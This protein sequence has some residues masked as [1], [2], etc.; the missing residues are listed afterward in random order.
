MDTSLQVKTNLK[1]LRQLKFPKDQKKILELLVET[2]NLLRNPEGLSLR[3]QEIVQIISDHK[4][5]SLDFLHR[6]FVTTSP[7]LLR[8]DL[9]YL[10]DNGYISK[11]GQTR[12]ALY[13][14]KQ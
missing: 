13:S 5:V 14:P 11:V 10:V 6:R 12:G 2:T 4:L 9:K 3:R 8:Y 7:R 1:L